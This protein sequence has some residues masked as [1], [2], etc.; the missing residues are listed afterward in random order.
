MDPD[1]LEFFRALFRIPG[2]AKMPARPVMVQEYKK[3]YW[4]Q[5]NQ[6]AR[7]GW[8]L[9]PMHPVYSGESQEPTWI[10]A[11]F[12]PVAEMTPATGGGRA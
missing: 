3:A 5:V 6:L 4:K 12:V 9:V 8:H 7:E 1:V 2:P 10:M 11:R